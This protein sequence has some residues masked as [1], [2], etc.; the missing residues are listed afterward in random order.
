MDSQRQSASCPLLTAWP[1]LS[2]Q[3]SYGPLRYHSQPRVPVSMQTEPL[4][5]HLLSLPQELALPLPWHCLA[6][7]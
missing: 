7:S 6:G 2:S 3:L 5:Y 1:A 4:S